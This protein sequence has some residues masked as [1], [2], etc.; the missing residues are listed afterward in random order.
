MSLLFL[1][2][3]SFMSTFANVPLCR[4]SLYVCMSGLY[5]DARD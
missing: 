3:L 1:L 2:Y 5:V 4:R